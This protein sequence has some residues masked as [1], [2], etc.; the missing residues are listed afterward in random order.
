MKK[1]VFILTTAL[2]LSG[3]AN[4]Q[5]SHNCGLQPYKPLSCMNGYAT[6]SCDYDGNCHWEFS[7]C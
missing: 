7:G 2:L 5:F 1:F 4:A 3:V 6:C